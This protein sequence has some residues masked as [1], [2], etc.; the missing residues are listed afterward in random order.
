MPE[1]LL[2]QIGTEDKKRL[3]AEKYGMVMTEEL[4][5][6]IKIMCNLSENIQAE[7]IKKGIEKG[8][9]KERLDAI[10]RMIRANASREQILSYGYTQ[11]EYDEAENTLLV[12]S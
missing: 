8:I 11:D 5:G 7:G 12:N 2:S 9:K 3:L 10:E 4:E 1:T 6:R